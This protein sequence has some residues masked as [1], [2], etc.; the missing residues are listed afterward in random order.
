L[1]FPDFVLEEARF[2]RTRKGNA[3]LFDAQGKTFNIFMMLWCKKKIEIIEK[4]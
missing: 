3:L 4:F 2:S 1:F